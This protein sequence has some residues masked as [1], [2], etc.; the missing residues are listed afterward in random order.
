M[1]M[2][3]FLNK[4]LTMKGKIFSLIA[5]STVWS[6]ISLA[7][8]N[9]HF[10]M[11]NEAPS[12]INPGATAVM[13]EDI[14]LFT[15]FRMQWTSLEGLPF[16]TNSFGIDAKLMKQKNSQSHLG[17]GVN[18][19]NDA[20]GDLKLTTNLISVPINYTIEADKNTLFSIGIAPGFYQQSI[21]NTNSTWNNQWNGITYDQSVQ[22]FE[23]FSPDNTVSTFDVGAGMHL[24]YKF[25]AMSN[26]N[27]GLSVNHITSPNV[28]FSSLANNLYRNVNIA[29]YGT[30]FSDERNFGFSPQ[31]LVQ[32]QG[33]NRNILFGTTFDHE[34]FESSKRTDYVQRSLVSYGIFMRWKD[35]VVGSL[36]V[37]FRGFKVGFSYD[38]NI[39]SLSPATR[40]MGGFELFL[41]Y[42]TL[43]DRSGYI[44]DRKLFRWNRGGGRAKRL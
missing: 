43:T 27:V 42:S 13:D 14:R 15:N 4:P 35:A 25:D 10:S 5:I 36:S 11:W 3:H 16:R 24:K 23:N 30:R 28:N 37:K 1:E 8:Q 39:S 22:S 19:T 38:F 12:A 32:L 34:L 41:K 7:Q 18:F 20:T 44:H 33:P 21:R 9:R 26:I 31:A 2:L 17:I 29:V 40:T 6:G